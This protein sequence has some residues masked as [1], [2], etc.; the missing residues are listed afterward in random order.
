MNY[1]HPLHRSFILLVALLCASASGAAPTPSGFTE[2]V[3][4]RVVALT[5][6]LRKKQGLQPVQPESR[7][8]DAARYF[9]AHIAKTDKLDHDAD[10]STPADRITKRGYRYC[11]VAENLSNEYSSGGFTPERLAENF[12]RG[13]NESPTHR[14]NMLESEFTQ[15]GLGIAPGNQPGEYYA[16]Q[17]FGRPFTQ[18]FKF[19]VTNRTVDTIRYEYRNRTVALNPTQMRTHESCLSGDLKFYWAGQQ[20]PTTV[21][22]KDGDRFAVVS[23]GRAYRLVVE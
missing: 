3:E 2:D 6:D 12:I 22:P 9:A 18:T 5:N 8:T 19:R 21:K 10:G 16:V 23:S 13:W 11:I 14:A 1:S 4:T 15:I 7:L 17:I 20:Q